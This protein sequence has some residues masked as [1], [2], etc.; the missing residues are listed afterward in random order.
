MNYF[1]MLIFGGNKDNLHGCN[2]SK[3]NN[4][5]V[6]SNSNVSPFFIQTPAKILEML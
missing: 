4:R 6:L 5:F 1:Q 2:Y 3:E